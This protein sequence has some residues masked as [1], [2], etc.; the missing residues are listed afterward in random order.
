MEKLNL[1]KVQ[2]LVAIVQEKK[3]DDLLPKENVVGFGIGNKISIDKTL[4]I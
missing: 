2:Q 3:S 1:S 4:M